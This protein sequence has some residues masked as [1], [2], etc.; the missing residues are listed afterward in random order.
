MKLKFNQLE[1]NK[2]KPSRDSSRTNGIAPRVDGGKCIVVEDEL[3]YLGGMTY[4]PNIDVLE[5]NKQ[6]FKLN[7][8]EGVKLAVNIAEWEAYNM[9]NSPDFR[10][11]L[12]KMFYIGDKILVHFDGYRS[13]PALSYN[14][15]NIENKDWFDEYYINEF[16]HEY[17][18]SIS[19]KKS[20]DY[21]PHFNVLQ[22]EHNLNK[23]YITN[24]FYL[25]TLPTKLISFDIKTKEMKTIHES[26]KGYSIYQQFVNNNKLYFFERSRESTNTF[27]DIKILNE[28]DLSSRKI[29]KHK[30]D[31]LKHLRLSVI[32]SNDSAYFILNPGGNS[33]AE[34]HKFDFQ[35]SEFKQV[36]KTVLFNGQECFTTYKNYLISSLGYYKISTYAGKNNINTHPHDYSLES[37]NK[38]QIYNLTSW[39][40]VQ[41]IP[42]KKSEVNEI[43]ETSKKDYI[44]VISDND[45]TS[46]L[47]RG[48]LSGIGLVILI[49]AVIV[50]IVYKHKL[51]K[52]KPPS[53]II[54]P[55]FIEPI[56]LS[57][58]QNNYYNT[59]IFSHSQEID[60]AI[61]ML[62]IKTYIKASAA[63]DGNKE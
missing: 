35:S 18:I 9:T 58:V 48:T 37:S 22:D 24:V 28:L 17:N 25:P 8:K 16:Y 5:Y 15:F 7:L 23:F 10:Y 2:K 30:M 43:K 55:I 6:L 56:D 61:T 20:I 59:E 13:E 12:T 4:I 62:R 29:Q 52:N 36:S 21:D 45:N 41:G 11:P 26:N 44:G 49:T 54:D 38:V 46:M 42:S 32:K 60:E 1:H 47:I 3:Y 51:R 50:F 39:E 27:S 31:F 33:T 34:I 14:S 63:T 19:K 40:Q 57:D 53:F